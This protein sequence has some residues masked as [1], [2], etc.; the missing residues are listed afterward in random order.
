MSPSARATFEDQP[1]EATTAPLI[2]I[3]G[4]GRAA[5]RHVLESDGRDFTGVRKTWLTLFETLKL[6]L[7]AGL[8]QDWMVLYPIRPHSPDVCEEQRCRRLNVVRSAFCDKQVAVVRTPAAEHVVTP[9]LV[10]PLLQ[11]GSQLE[12]YM[13]AAQ[14]PFEP[15]QGLVKT[16]VVLA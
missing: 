5:L 16:Q 2:L 8:L 4:D 3:R 14:A 10:Y 13:R 7:V 9:L 6:M 12:G 1:L 11:A 15:K